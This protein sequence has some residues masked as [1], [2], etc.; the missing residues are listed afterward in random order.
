M[1]GRTASISCLAGMDASLLQ[2]KVFQRHISKIAPGG[3][4]VVVAGDTRESIDGFAQAV[5][6][7][8]VD[9]VFAD[10]YFAPVHHTVAGTDVVRE[11]RARDAAAG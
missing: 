10:Q 2:R 11:I 4:P 7:A 9:V 1:G 8:D 3:P 6:D 5:C